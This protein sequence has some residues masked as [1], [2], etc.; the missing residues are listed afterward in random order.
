MK[1][2]ASLKLFPLFTYYK[3]NVEIPVVL[4]KGKP[5]SLNVKS[6]LSIT[7]KYQLDCD[8]P[9]Q[10]TVPLLSSFLFSIKEISYS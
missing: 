3:I 9:E 5:L 4:K 8:L 6:V 1:N 7:S 2:P 10:D